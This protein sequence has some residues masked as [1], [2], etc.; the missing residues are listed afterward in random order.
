MRDTVDAG[1]HSIRPSAMST[2]A[3]NC[4]R[5]NDVRLFQFYRSLSANRSMKL[6]LTPEM[7]QKIAARRFWMRV[8]ILG[9]LVVLGLTPWAHAQLPPPN[10]PAFCPPLTSIATPSLYDVFFNTTPIRFPYQ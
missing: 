5:R 10:E 9:G 3:D 6:N 1:P 4:A 2:R 7:M 8:I